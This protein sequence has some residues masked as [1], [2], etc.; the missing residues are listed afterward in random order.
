MNWLIARLSPLQK[1]VIASIIDASWALVAFPLAYFLRYGQ[2]FPDI[3]ATHQVAIQTLLLAVVQTGCFHF[4]GMYRSIWRYSSTPDLIRLIKGVTT[5]T[6][7][8]F[9]V[10]FLFNRLEHTPRSIFIINWLLLVTGLGGWRFLYRAFRDYSLFARSKNV[11]ERII[12]IGAGSG[13]EK[14]IREIHRTPSLKMQI[15]AALDDDPGKQNKLLHGVP[16][17]GTIDDLD[18]VIAKTSANRIFI[19]I[20]TATGAELNRVV[21]AC[22]KSQVKFKT[23][24]PI[25]DIINGHISLEQ[26]RSVEPEDLLGRQ[27]IKLDNSSINEML[28]HGPVLVTG[29]GGSIGSEICRQIARFSP[30]E[31]ILFEQSELSLY[32]IENEFRQKFPLIPIRCIIGD[33]RNENDLENVFS[34]HKP[35]VVFHAAAYK[36]VPLME[37]NPKSAIKTNIFGT[38]N[39]AQKS[40]AYKVKKFVM[41][42]TDK[43]VNPTSVMGATKRLAEM[44]CASLQQSS[45]TQFVIVRFGNVLGSSGSV[46]PFFKQQIKR[47]GPV[48]VTHPEI[49]RYFMSISEASQLVLQAGALGNGSEIFVLN[50][51]KPV[52]ILDLAKQLIV[53]SGFK[54]EQDIKIEFTG[55]RPGEKLYEELLFDNEKTLPTVHP[56]LRVAKVYQKDF[57]LKEVLDRL[58][59]DIESLSFEFT[60]E[61]LSEFIPEY[62][63]DH[64]V[65]PKQNS[66][67]A[68]LSEESESHDEE[69]EEDDSSYFI[70]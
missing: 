50:M 31:I 67:E 63:P 65:P 22:R 70:H 27:Q 48:T 23:L 59:K 47:G 18:S 26:L 7:L 1:K 20:P 6:F 24:P 3:F 8:S 14:L 33:I 69:G 56:M 13:G 15:V 19:A 64:S 53:L 68:S 2:A 29:A 42:S 36:H 43:A 44:L 57:D 62:T 66:V 35:A 25:N 4:Y 21:Q 61:L 45:K 5:S 30:I 52:K 55:L 39:L 60:K 17:M 51:G 10:I 28:E 16:V 58:N 32:Q 9:A 11:I 54:P 12:I 46:I 34:R 49:E 37:M 41:I 38:F 40:I